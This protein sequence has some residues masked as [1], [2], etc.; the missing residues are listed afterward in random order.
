VSVLRN[1][2]GLGSAV[3]P[4]LGEVPEEE[5][6]RLVR[7]IA[8]A[9]GKRVARKAQ[10]AAAAGVPMSEEAE[11]VSSVTEIHAELASY[12]ESRVRTGGSPLSGFAQEA[13]VDVVL[14]HVYGLGEL[15]IL[16]RD[17][18]VENIVVNGP[19]DVFVTTAGGMKRRW[20]PIARDEEELNDLIRRAARQLG[21]NEVEFDARHPM[22]DLQLPDGS[23][24]FAVYGGEVGNGVGVEPYLCIRRHRHLNVEPARIGPM[25][26]IP[27]PA[28]DFVIKAFGA[29]ENL[30]VAGDY[31]AGKTTLLRAVCFAGIPK[32]QRV[33]TVEAF[34]TELGLHTA[35]DR[36]DDVSALYSRPPS[37]EGEGE[38]TVR[39]LIRRATRRMNGTRV[40]VGEI[41]GDEVGP[42]LDVFSASTRGSACT[43]H[44]RSARGVVRR[45]EQYGLMSHPIVPPE[46]INYGL[47][48]A[49][50]IILHL[51]GDE[52]VAGKLRRYCTSIVE[53]TGLEDGKVATTELWGLDGD[54]HL[55][56]RHALSAARR[57]RLARAGWDRRV[58]GWTSTNGDGR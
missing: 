35:K 5:R 31:N 7:H 24:L 28:I 22:L 36:L 34:I 23:R 41:L 38:V 46:A 13:M 56:P 15:D 39:D 55:V 26:A 8:D 4:T 51:A 45:F 57:D 9:V 27:E 11:R 48:E 2:V 50:P 18:S 33:I 49:S 3:D 40:I 44:A 14:A 37:A 25:W 53:V 1:A 32:H 42:A 47:A 43:I 12:N 29:G 30:I 21:H 6:R 17:E 52:S 16:W 20:P 58:Q 19:S 10:E 54:G